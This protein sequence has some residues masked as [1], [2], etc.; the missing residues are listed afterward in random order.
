MPIEPTEPESSPLPHIPDGEAETYRLYRGI[1]GHTFGSNKTQNRRTGKTAGMV[2]FPYK[3]IMR[4]SY[5]LVTSYDLNKS[6]T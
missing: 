4:L 1:S 2:G 5:N 6:R 3:P